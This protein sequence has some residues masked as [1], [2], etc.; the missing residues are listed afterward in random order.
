MSVNKI[1]TLLN[2]IFYMFLYY[3]AAKHGLTSFLSLYRLFYVNHLPISLLDIRLKP[4]VIVA[5]A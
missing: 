4:C 2:I 3:L 5:G 1:F